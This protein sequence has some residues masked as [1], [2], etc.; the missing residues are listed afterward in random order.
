MGDEGQ[1]NTVITDKSLEDLFKGT[2]T[3]DKKNI[4]NINYIKIELQVTYTNDKTNDKKNFLLTYTYDEFKAKLLV[5]D[6]YIKSSEDS[7]TQLYNDSYDSQ[8]VQFM[9]IVKKHIDY[10]RHDSID[11]INLI[12]EPLVMMKEQDGGKLKNGQKKKN[13]KKPVVSQNKENK[14]KEVL[15][16]MMKIYKK[17]DSRKEFVRYKGELVPLVEYKKTM[18]EIVRAKNKKH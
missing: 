11:K 3:L 9:I 2:D 5:K 1:N 18:K 8:S 7:V 16:K 10:E 15:G 14:Y 12:K 13:S 17:P 6:I 4:L